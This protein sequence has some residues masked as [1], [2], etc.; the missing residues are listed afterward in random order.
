[1]SGTFNVNLQRD[2][3]AANVSQVTADAV[4]AQHAKLAAIEPPASAS[5]DSRRAIY[6][7]VD[8]AFV[9]GFRRVMLIA[10]SLALASA[11]S[12]WM[13]IGGGLAHTQPH[14]N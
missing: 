13:M 8:E 1:M 2:L 10:A 12:A 11:I 3:A 14:E 5:A 6:R 7:A 9:S 4:S